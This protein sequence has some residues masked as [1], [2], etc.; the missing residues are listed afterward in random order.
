MRA[1]ALVGFQQLPQQF[2]TAQARHVEIQH[3]E[4]R[5]FAFL[6]CQRGVAAVGL[7]HRGAGIGAKLFQPGADH[8]M[9]V[10]NQNLH[11][12][13]SLTPARGIIASMRVPPP[14]RTPRRSSPFS[15]ESLSRMP[16]NPMPPPPCATNPT[17]SSSTVT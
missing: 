12:T 11:A 14:G 16:F 6:Q 3:R 1:R 5:T 9:I 4:L 8:R 17:P 10:D 7:Q 15:A 2:K 13:A